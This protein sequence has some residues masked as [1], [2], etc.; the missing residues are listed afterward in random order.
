MFN[1]LQAGAGRWASN[2]F[3]R[4]HSKSY[5][6]SSRPDTKK[7]ASDLSGGPTRSSW[8]AGFT[9]QTRFRMLA[10]AATVLVQACGGGSRPDGGIHAVA[11]LDAGHQTADA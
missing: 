2:C 1:R 5:C 8:E 11:E 6:R 9:M 10:L 4:G 3:R 7:P